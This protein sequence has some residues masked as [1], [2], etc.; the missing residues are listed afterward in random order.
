[1]GATFTYFLAHSVVY[2]TK[3]MKIKKQLFGTLIHSWRFN[4][5]QPVLGQRKVGRLGQ[6]LIGAH[7]GHINSSQ[8]LNCDCQA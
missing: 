4:K 8:V 3:K 7:I 1:M 5:Q 2:K 6:N